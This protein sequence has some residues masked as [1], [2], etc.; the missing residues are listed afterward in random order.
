MKKR[1]RAF[2][3]ARL[4][5]WTETQFYLAQ[6]LAGSHVIFPGGLKWSLKII[7]INFL[8]FS[9]SGHGCSPSTFFIP[10][11]ICQYLIFINNTLTNTTANQ[12]DHSSRN[13][14]VI[15]VVLKGISNSSSFYSSKDILSRAMI[16][17][18]NYS[19]FT[20]CTF[21]LLHLLLLEL[22]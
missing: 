6:P 22:L 2:K 15:F 12:P 9:W 5:Q 1:S 8:V 17:V 19:L 20:F 18:Q 4:K 13:P 21:S 3:P 14:C 16:L 10:R 11:S 7:L